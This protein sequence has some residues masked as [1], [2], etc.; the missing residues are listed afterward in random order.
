VNQT[1]EVLPD[2]KKVGGLLNVGGGSP[3]WVYLPDWENFI[4]TDNVKRVKFNREP[5]TVEVHYVDGC[6][7]IYRDAADVAA[8]T[9]T[10]FG[11]S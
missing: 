2:L 6:I 5:A 8:L 10:F 1:S 7:D 3:W 4:N 11:A 9:E